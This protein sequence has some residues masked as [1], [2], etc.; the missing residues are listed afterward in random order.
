MRWKRT[1][2]VA[3]AAAGL[4]FAATPA[5]FSAWTATKSG[6]AYAGAGYWTQLRISGSNGHCVN[7]KSCVY[8]G[9]GNN[10]SF[11]TTLAVTDGS[12]NIVSNLGSGHTVTVTITQNQSGGQ[13]TSPSTPGTSARTLSFPSS[14]QAV[15][16][17]SFTYKTGT[18]NGWTDK[19]AVASSDSYV[20][21]ASLTLSK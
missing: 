14:G 13:F 6:S 1:L 15:T 18:G 4:V 2:T 19:L 8:S 20:S 9:I 21:S 12:G 7:A 16:T 17:A 5:A 10:A 11:T 3:V